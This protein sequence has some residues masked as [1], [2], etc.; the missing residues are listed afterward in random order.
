ML[1]RHDGGWERIGQVDFSLR[2][3]RDTINDHDNFYSFALRALRPDGTDATA[4]GYCADQDGGSVQC[5]VEC[6]GGNITLRQHDGGPLALSVEP[7]RFLRLSEDCNG[8]SFDLLPEDGILYA[9]PADTALCTA[10]RRP[11]LGQSRPS[12]EERNGGP[13]GIEPLTSCMPCKRSPS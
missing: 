6:D 2:Y 9:E 3:D 10:V 5:M 13:S 11:R 12:I 4:Q 7:G 8:A 1:A